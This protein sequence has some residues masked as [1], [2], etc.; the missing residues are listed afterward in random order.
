MTS[1]A[2]RRGTGFWY[3]LG[4]ARSVRIIFVCMVVYFLII[5]GLVLGYAKVQ[6]CIADYSEVQNISSRA[7]SEAATIDRELNARYDELSTAERNR[8]GT[9]QD[10][11]LELMD[12]LA[13]PE[14]RSPVVVRVALAKV[15]KVNEESRRIS[16]VNDA[17]RIQLDQR[18]AKAEALRQL[19]PVPEAPSKKC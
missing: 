3:N 1:Q 7:R 6:K 17:E 10:A 8:L 9:D 18:R 5:G 11:F 2:H 15:R 4:S 14:A 12:V 16:K 13:S 19:N